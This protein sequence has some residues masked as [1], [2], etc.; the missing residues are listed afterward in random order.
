MKWPRVDERFEGAGLDGAPT[1]ALPPELGRIAKKSQRSI[2]NC[3]TSTLQK[4]AP[5]LQRLM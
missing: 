1:E 5:T 3:V 2:E 4:P